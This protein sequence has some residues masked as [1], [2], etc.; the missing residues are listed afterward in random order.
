MAATPHKAD[1]LA[2]IQRGED[3]RSVAACYSVPWGTV[4]VWMSRWRKAGKLSESPP[5]RPVADVV[6]LPAT[7]QQTRDQK[8]IAAQQQQRQDRIASRVC[9]TPAVDRPTLRRIARTLIRKLDTGLM[10]P[11]CDGEEAQPL[12]PNEFALYTK[13][14]VQHLDALARSLEVE[15]QLSDTAATAAA[16]L[17]DPE[18]LAEI[19]RNLETIGARR[20]SEVL[21]DNDRARA[22]VE[23]ALSHA[24][25]STG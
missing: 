15:E 13:A 6:A 20:L 7:P 24:Q 4:R 2:A 18:V 3:P 8:R 16:D 14:Y 19:G 25:R 10:C 22:I 11:T 23:A 5:P 21:S 12:K 1:V 17:D 9:A